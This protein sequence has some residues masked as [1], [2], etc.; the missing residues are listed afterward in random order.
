MFS[1]S[2]V[3]VRVFYLEHVAQVAT[4]PLISLVLLSGVERSINSISLWLSFTYLT[5][6][7][8]GVMVKLSLILIDQ[9]S[10]MKSI[11]YPLILASTLS[12]EATSIFIFHS[13]IHP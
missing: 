11:V 4:P 3:Y 12:G 6:M 7:V 9:L 5:S 1:D 2:L 13:T 10:G 8:S